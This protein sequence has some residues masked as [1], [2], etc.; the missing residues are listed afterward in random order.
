MIVGLEVVGV[1]G[2]VAGDNPRE[3]IGLGI[4]LDGELPRRGHLHPADPARHQQHRIRA[5]GLRGAQSVLGDGKRLVHFA[6]IVA[7]ELG[8]AAQHRVNAHT[9]F[10]RDFAAGL[11]LLRRH[12]TGLD[13]VEAGVLKPLQLVFRRLADNEGLEELGLE[14]RRT[15]LGA[16]G[17]GAQAEAEPGGQSG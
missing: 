2:V 10:L 9:A 15:L 17:N 12:D 8:P 14:G 5:V 13:A 11:R 16:D 3:V 4:K 6:L 7:V 1:R